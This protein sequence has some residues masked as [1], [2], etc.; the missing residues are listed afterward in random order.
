[1]FALLDMA[2]ADGYIGSFE[3][4]YR[5]LFWRPV[6]AIHM[7][8]TDGSPATEPDPGWTLLEPTPAIPDHDSA[9]SVEGGAAAA[10]LGR[11]LGTDRVRFT[12]C[13]ST[14]PAGS[15]CGEADPVLRRFRSLSAAAAENGRSRILIGF[16]FRKAVEDGIEHGRRIGNRAVMQF[17]WPVRR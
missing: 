10:V 17:M 7:A 12:A 3:A 11:V 6:T 5:H 2:L 13:S 16:H 8:T 1:M 4:K 9:H 14:L 15:N